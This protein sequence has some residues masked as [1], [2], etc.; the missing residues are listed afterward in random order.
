MPIPHPNLLLTEPH[1][2]SHKKIFLGK[3]GKYS[4]NCVNFVFIHNNN[5][6]FFVFIRAQARYK[7]ARKHQ[8][9]RLVRL[10]QH[11]GRFS[12]V[13]KDYPNTKQ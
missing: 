3:V 12:Y 9:S 7:N 6:V 2:K 13:K 8:G 1:P 10:E 5:H 11:N 4:E